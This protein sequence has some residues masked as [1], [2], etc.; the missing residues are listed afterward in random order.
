M[1]RDPEH[2]GAADPRAREQ[3]LAGRMTTYQELVDLLVES[4]GLLVVTS[5]PWSGTSTLLPYALDALG[6]AS[7]LVDA[8]PSSDA[9]DLAMAFADAA[10][11]RLAPGATSWWG[12]TGPPTDRDALRLA[13]TLSVRGV[14]LDG[15]RSRDGLGLEQLAEAVELTL[16]LSEDR[17]TIVVDHAGLLLAGLSDADA[18]ELLGTLRA[19]RQQHALLD[20]VLVEHPGGR[21]SA[22]LSDARHPLYRAGQRLRVERPTH[23]QFTQDLS[24]LSG[25]AT[26][27]RQLVAVAADLAGGVPWVTWEVVAFAPVGDD[28]PPRVRALTGWHR[29]RGSTACATAREWDLLRRVHPLAQWIVAAL[30]CSLGPHAVP[31][32]PKSVT[33]ALHRMRDLG[34]AWQPEPRRWALSDPL[35]AAW[36][37][38]H[39]PAWVKRRRPR[40]EPLR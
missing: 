13:R 22:A 24:S 7:V 38:D 12:G 39:P 8:R 17:V 32:N 14:D 6:T 2:R 36:C 30:A 10:V 16:A 21:A 1:V 3:A 23:E 37:R 15:L 11:A 25:W 4:P 20:L 35:L 19:L 33:A 40:P 5:D 34:L 18:R 27:Q 9:H 29:L 31:A 28:E 26:S